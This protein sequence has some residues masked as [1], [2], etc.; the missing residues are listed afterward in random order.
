MRWEQLVNKIKSA[1]VQF[2]HKPGDKEYNL[3]KVI[4]FVEV[5]K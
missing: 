5:L 4:E 3:G 2:N 1:S